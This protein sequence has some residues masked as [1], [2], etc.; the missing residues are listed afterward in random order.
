LGR[1]NV[2]SGQIWLNGSGLDLL[3]GARP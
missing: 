2:L 3:R 1:V